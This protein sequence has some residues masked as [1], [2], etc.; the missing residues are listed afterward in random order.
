MKKKKKKKKLKK[1]SY[2]SSITDSY[3]AVLMQRKTVCPQCRNEYYGDGRII[4]S[5]S[6]LDR[7]ISTTMRVKEI[8]GK[9]E[10]A[11]VLTR[12]EKEMHDRRE[13]NKKM[14]D[15]KVQRVQRFCSWECVKERS[16]T[17]VPKA[18]RYEMYQLIDLYAGYIVN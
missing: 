12:K 1:S 17:A 2:G 10:N 6:S 4:P 5:I 13:R 7:Q 14:Y 18:Y 15:M 9:R 8:V 3:D 16:I 11:D